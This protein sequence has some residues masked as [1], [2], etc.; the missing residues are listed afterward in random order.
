[1]KSADDRFAKTRWPF[2]IQWPVSGRCDAIG[3]GSGKTRPET[4]VRTAPVVMCHPLAEHS[5]HVAFTEQDHTIQALT[6]NA[7]DQ[8][9]AER[10]GLRRPDWRP[11]DDPDRLASGCNHRRVKL[12][13]DRTARAVVVR[14]ARSTVGDSSG[15]LGAGAA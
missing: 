14:R 7:A 4:R 1:M 6:S 11:A 15:V 9:L 10:V 2:R 3:R 5:P 8:S 12:A 13:L